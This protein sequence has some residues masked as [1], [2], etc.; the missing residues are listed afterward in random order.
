MS[1]GFDMSFV[2]RICVVIT[3]FLLSS[4]TN[5]A[6]TPREI[7]DAIKKGAKAL[8]QC[9]YADLDVGRSALAGIA[10]LESEE[11]PIN[12]PSLKTITEKIQNESWKQ[13]KT[14]ELSL[15]L[16]YL[17]RLGDPNDEVLIQ[18]LG[19]RL[20]AG[21]SANGG[22]NYN[23]IAEPPQK[24]VDV[25]R[26][27]KPIE[28]QGTPKLHPKVE[29]Y[30]Q[31]LVSARPKTGAIKDDNSNTQF[32][33]IALWLSRKHGIP[34]EPALQAIE[35]RFMTTQGE[36]GG[37]AYLG[38]PEGKAQGEVESSSPSMFCPGL[39]GL[40]TAIA[41]RQER[42]AKDEA[43]KKDNKKPVRYMSDE[44]DK[45]VSKAWIGL[46]KIVAASAKEK[47]G[48]LVLEGGIQG[49]HDLYFYWSLECVCVI[50]GIEKLGGVDWYE[51]GAHTLV[52]RQAANGLWT[53]GG[54][55]GPEVN[56]SF[57]LLFL[58]RSNL[59]RDLSGKVQIKLDARFGKPRGISS[60]IPR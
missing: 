43:P 9:N 17:D 56:T 59:V 16:M 40:S 30:Q 5:S 22:W 50:Y 41:R 31:K 20:L 12:D 57:A 32:A 58:L 52:T 21:Q 38:P 18:V 34:V 6:A 26:A 45:A 44:M 49:F 10:L 8:K 36:S 19:V 33:M 29:K 53:T 27:I 48:A 7:K 1:G 28:Q 42:R 23:C 4:G 54:S 2:M 13:F 39:I 51:T 37:W 14:Y 25:L 46:G 47:Q 11:V 24:E 35:T 3:L 15:C 55:Y 60:T